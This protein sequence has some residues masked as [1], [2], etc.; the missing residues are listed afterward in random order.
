M[1]GEATAVLT[2]RQFAV[3][4]EKTRLKPGE[5]IT[6]KAVLLPENEEQ[7]AS[8]T[9]SDE[10]VAEVDAATGEI[11]A[12]AEG[13]A[14]I[15]AAAKDGSGLTGSVSIEVG[16]QKVT[17]IVVTAEKT[18][19]KPGEKTM[20]MAAVLPEDASNKEVTWTSSN[21][22]AATVDAASGEIM[23]VAEG[24]AEI[25]AAAKDGSGITGSVSIE[26]EGDGGQETVKVTGITV[27]AGKTKLKPD[28][29]SVV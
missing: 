2:V 4:V 1:S 9:S 13:A 15:T 26:V 3:T 24:T 12:V 10:T 20:A 21:E 18:K 6:A 25:I 19:L 22:A 28:R 5:K 17:E 11:T 29:K 27:T 14:E 16:I 8:W 23:A 7:E